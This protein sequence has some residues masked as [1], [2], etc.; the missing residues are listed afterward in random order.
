MAWSKV[1]YDNGVWWNIPVLLRGA[2]MFAWL[3][4]LVAPLKYVYTLFTTNRNGN[5]YRLAHNGQVCK[6]EAVLN[7]TFDNTLRRIY[8]SDGPFKE[9]LYIAIRDEQKPVALYTQAESQPKYIYTRA[10]TAAVGVQFYVNVPTAVSLT[11]AY[12][13]IRIKSLVNRYRLAGKKNYQI[14]IF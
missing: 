11:P 6:L 3:K 4:L 14:V 9:A 10:E 13:T 5:L 12:S 7:D 2:L 8:I 1:D